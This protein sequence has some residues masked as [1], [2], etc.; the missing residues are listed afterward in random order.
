MLKQQGVGV[1][2][3]SKS[4]PVIEEV[5]QLLEAGGKTE[6]CLVIE[7]YA[8]DSHLPR[9]ISNNFH[10]ISRFGVLMAVQRLL[11]PKKTS[12]NSL[13]EI[14]TSFSIPTILMI[15]EKIITYA[16]GLERIAFR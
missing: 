2:G 13:V 4:A 15:R 8:Q 10:I 6:V 9:I 5:P 3:G 11:F 14:A 1:K 12:V 7:F 16:T